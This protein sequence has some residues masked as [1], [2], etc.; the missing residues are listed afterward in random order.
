MDGRIIDATVMPAPKQR[1]TQDEK[2]ARKEGRA[3]A[4]GSFKLLKGQDTA[5]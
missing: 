1:N 2:I 5:N 3:S 4:E